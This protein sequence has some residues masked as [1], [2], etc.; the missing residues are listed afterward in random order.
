MP[1]E[2]GSQLISKSAPGPRYS[3][4]LRMEITSNSDDAAGHV[5][6]L[7]RRTDTSD[8]CTVTESILIFR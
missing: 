5:Y 4:Y 3:G 2:V 7:R 8:S 6:V 1:P